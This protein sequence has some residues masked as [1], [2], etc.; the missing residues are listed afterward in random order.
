MSRERSLRAEPEF[1]YDGCLILT[2]IRRHIRSELRPI[3]ARSRSMAVSILGSTRPSPTC[4]WAGSRRP[5][6]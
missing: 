5:R 1:F 3:L 4:S 6:P 2:E